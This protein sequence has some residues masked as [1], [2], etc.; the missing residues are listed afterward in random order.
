MIWDDYLLN[1]KKFEKSAA[2]AVNSFCRKNADDLTI[3]HAK[4]QVEILKR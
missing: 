3:I 1:I 2:K 4:Y